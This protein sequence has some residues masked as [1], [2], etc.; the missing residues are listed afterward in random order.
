MRLVDSGSTVRGIVRVDNGDDLLGALEALAAATAWTEALVTGAGSVSLIELAGS[1]GSAVGASSPTDTFE[2]AEI[3]QLSGR[4]ARRAEGCVVTLHATLIEH[5]NVR[6]GRIVAAIANELLLAVDAITTTH[7]AR[8][9]PAQEAAQVTRA[10]AG[11]NGTLTAA[12]P[13]PEAPRPSATTAS[14]APQATPPSLPL[15]QR[16]ASLAAQ[17]TLPAPLAPRP[18]ATRLRENGIADDDFDNEVEIQPGDLLEHPQLGSC[19][20]VG[21]D[22][23]GGTRVRMPSGRVGVL[24]LDTLRILPPPDEGASPRVYRVAGP[25]KRS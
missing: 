25:R 11:A 5:G 13:H 17:P 2:D 12:S 24:R 7:A 18:L 15:P 19:E 21:D 3:V 1:A 23:S 16:P 9:L 14:A 20:V 6:I 8:A 4:I 10:D 22:P